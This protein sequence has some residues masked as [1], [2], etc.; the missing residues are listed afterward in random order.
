MG[1]NGTNAAVLPENTSTADLIRLINAATAA[2]KD[3]M[4]GVSAEASVKQSA[5]ANHVRE[6][7]EGSG[8]YTSIV[9]FKDRVDDNLLR[10][11]SIITSPTS[12]DCG[13]R[14]HSATLVAFKT[15]GGI[16]YRV[17]ASWE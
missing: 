13:K 4:A 7:V 3:K 2:L 14:G 11:A 9:D 10:D 8:L 17:T 16:T 6:M 12:A 5:G 15:D 1:T